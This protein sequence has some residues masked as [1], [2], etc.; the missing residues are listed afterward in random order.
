VAVQELEVLRVLVRL[1]LLPDPVVMVET[2]MQTPQVDLE[3]QR[4]Q[5][6]QQVQMALVVAGVVEVSRLALQQV[7]AV[8]AVRETS[9]P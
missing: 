7:L 4:I 1:S 3:A 5:Q 8:L 9:M 6:A 2:L